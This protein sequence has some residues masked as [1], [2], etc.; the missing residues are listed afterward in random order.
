MPYQMRIGSF[1]P[2]FGTHTH[3]QRGGREREREG[4]GERE[5]EREE[6]NIHMILS[7]ASFLWAKGKRCYAWQQIEFV[8]GIR[9]AV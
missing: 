4:E 3:T 8:Y 6:E 5:R 7:V 2:N 9:G 1:F